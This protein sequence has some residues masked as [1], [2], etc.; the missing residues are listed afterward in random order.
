LVRGA[1]QPFGCRSLR[2][3][4]V[5]GRFAGL[6]NRLGVDRC[7]PATFGVGSRGSPTVW[8]SIAALPPRLGLVRGA[9][10]PFGCRSLRSR[11]VWG[12]FAGL[13]NRL[14]VVRCAHDTFDGLRPV[15]EKLAVLAFRLALR[16]F[17]ASP[18]YPPRISQIS[19]IE[20][21]STL[22]CRSLRSR[23]AWGW[24]AGL[25]NR[26]GVVRCAHD[27]F[28]GLRQVGEKLAVLAFRLALRAFGAS[29]KYLP[30]ISQ[31]SLI[32]AN[33]TFVCRSLLSRHAWGWFAGL[34]NRLGV[35]RCAHDTFDG[36]R[37][38]GEKL[39]VLA[40]R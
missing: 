19:L 30:R 29:P 33:S 40:F 15:G 10:Q 24:F 23:H 16:A 18:K 1:H 6:T 3:R 28:D 14:S 27:T 4:H 12:W 17:G 7:A 35:V 36:L 11:H 9:H 37:P 20:A 39:A 21:N 22:G 26:L 25:T 31:I 38:V 8:V 2:S 5:W 34:T 13:T 32:E